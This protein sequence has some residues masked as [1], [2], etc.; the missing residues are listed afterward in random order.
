MATSFKIGKVVLGSLFKKPATLMYPVVPREWQERTRGAIGIVEEDCILCGICS[1]RCPTLAIDVNRDKRFWAIERM[2]CVQ[3]GACV[4]VCPKKCLIMEQ[5]YTAP[6]TAKVIDT[7]DIPQKA[8]ASGGGSAAPADGTLQCDLE[9]CI[10]CG[11]CVK[12]CPCDA[13]VVDRKADPK[14]WKVDLDA[15]GNCG[16]CVEKCP[17]KCLAIK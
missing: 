6:S 8:A 7:Y 14:V 5:Q 1:K 3:C 17:K 9:A 10:Y 11:I 12:Q 2:N 15:C 13:L 16:V 4:S